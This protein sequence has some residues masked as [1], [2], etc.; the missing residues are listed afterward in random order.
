[1][2][3]KYKMRPN[4]YL[5]KVSGV[6]I[7]GRN[8]PCNLRTNFQ[9]SLRPS[10]FGKITLVDKKRM[11]PF[12]IWLATAYT[13]E[14]AREGK[15]YP[16]NTNSHFWV[17]SNTYTQTSSCSRQLQLPTWNYY[18]SWPGVGRPENDVIMFLIVISLFS[19]SRVLELQHSTAIASLGWDLRN[20]RTFRT[21]HDSVLSL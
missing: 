21:P 13:Y 20:A 18:I 2:G 14:V 1:M 19:L 10:I 6:E 5:I 4:H 7:W 16:K 17:L 15:F 3:T 11:F 9:R 12:H 8:Q